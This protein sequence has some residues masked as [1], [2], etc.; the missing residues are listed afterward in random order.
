MLVIKSS[1]WLLLSAQLRTA[2][3]TRSACGPTA[4]MQGL[5][6]R[7]QRCP[8]LSSIPNIYLTQFCRCTVNISKEEGSKVEK[9]Q[10]STSTN[11]K[12]QKVMKNTSSWDSD[13][14][15]WTGCWQAQRNRTAKGKQHGQAP[16]EQSRSTPA[17]TALL[18]HP[19]SPWNQGTTLAAH[20]FCH[21]M[22]CLTRCLF[23]LTSVNL[24]LVALISPCN[25]WDPFG[26]SNG[27]PEDLA[28]CMRIFWQSNILFQSQ[29]ENSCSQ[30][31]GLCVT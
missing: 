5:Q 28:W 20:W 4:S 17:G 19:S 24:S 6:P 12:K 29:D 18:S 23:S 27:Q 8:S 14:A 15:C 7:P 21:F 30:H 13:P 31:L 3:L 16:G 26:F 2:S 1:R 9:Q 22:S 25:R 11:H 10:I